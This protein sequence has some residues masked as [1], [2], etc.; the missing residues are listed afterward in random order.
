MTR[1][2]EDVI[3]DVVNRGEYLASAVAEAALNRAARILRRASER[4]RARI[5]SRAESE[6]IGLSDWRVVRDI[7]EAADAVADRAL[8][9]RFRRD[10]WTV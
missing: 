5:L 9:E 8:D 4:V 10:N 7:E 6:T 1:Q 3:L 2:T